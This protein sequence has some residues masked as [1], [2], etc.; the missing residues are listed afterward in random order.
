MIKSGPHQLRCGPLHFG[1]AEG[2]LGDMLFLSRGAKKACPPI[3]PR[4]VSVVHVRERWNFRSGPRSCD[5]AATCGLAILAG[6]G[7]SRVG[8]LRPCA[9]RRR[10]QLRPSAPTLMWELYGRG[11]IAE[12]VSRNSQADVLRYCIVSCSGI[13]HRPEPFSPEEVTT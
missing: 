8:L 1:A 6:N 7:T 12:S 11:A 4:T 10:S 13:Y 2:Q 9:N 5:R 3:A